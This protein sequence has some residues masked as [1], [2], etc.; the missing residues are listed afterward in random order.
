[1]RMSDGLRGLWGEM[2]QRRVVGAVAAYAAVAFVL[3]QLSEIIFPAFGIGPSAVRVLV[4]ALL[5]G[6]PLVLALS[7]VYDLTRTG[8]KR[9]GARRG[10]A[11]VSL[12]MPVITAGVVLSAAGLGLVGWWAVRSAELGGAP[13]SVQSSI[14]VL[15]FVDMSELGDQ[16]YLGDGLAEEI[17]NLLAGIDGLHVAARTSAFAF[18]GSAQDIRDVGAQLGVATVLEGS[19]RR[20]SR[21]VRIT[22]QLID[23]TTGFHLWSNTYD[24]EI[25]DMF[26]VQDEI[27]GAIASALLGELDVPP[28]AGIRHVAPPEARD[29]YWQ[30]RAQWNRRDA[31]GVPGALRLFE[32]A[33]TVDPDYAE[34]YAGLA[35]AYALLPQVV[36]G[37][38]MAVAVTRAE[39]AA[40]KALELDPDLA[41]AHSSLGLVRALKG[42]RAGALT[43]LDRALALNPSH[44]VALHWRGNVLAE[45][46][47]LTAASADLA[48]AA[49]LDPLSPA[50]ATDKGNMHLWMQ[51]I[52]A[53]E[54]S[55]DDALALDFR[56]GPALFGRAL[57][58]LEREEPVALRMALAQWG[59]VSGM[60]PTLAA[61]LAE[62]MMAYRQTGAAGE[63][64]PALQRVAARTNLAKAGVLASLH[65]LTGAHEEAIGW[66]QRSVD[67]G[68]WVDQY[69]A[70]NPIYDRIREDPRFLEVITL[71]SK[72]RQG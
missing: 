58:A 19:V 59:A 50:I 71:V 49:K 17:L 23:A 32:R 6:F 36:A 2:K 68:S 33:L 40:R 57:V 29:A 35:D 1:M 14:A 3:L 13:T 10:G 53:A 42:D 31:A 44:A 9:T 16:G 64:P 69:L 30:G 7:W 20:D 37:I 65:A 45:S 24:R 51:E 15:P 4:G 61:E 5:A 11:P 25:E 39:S 21:R 60:P 26:A 8:L 62:A 47:Q 46:G 27:A 67:D 43:S 34:A 55:F 72:P 63:A 54:A 66:L 70:V 38:D 12:P 41:D 28:R 22:A 18:R 56:F 48:R 52:D